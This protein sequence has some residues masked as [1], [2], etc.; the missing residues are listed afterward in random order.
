MTTDELPTPYSDPDQKK[1]TVLLGGIAHNREVPKPNECRSITVR[2][3]GV[4][5]LYEPW[6]FAVQMEDGKRYEVLRWGLGNPS[7]Y[8]ARVLREAVVVAYATVLWTYFKATQAPC[9]K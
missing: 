2:Q 5:M 9:A 1:R 7:E 8:E 3:S 4:E 6:R